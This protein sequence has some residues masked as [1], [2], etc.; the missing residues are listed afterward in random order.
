MAMSPKLLMK[1]LGEAPNLVWMERIDVGEEWGK[2]FH[3]PFANELIHVLEGSARIEYQRSAVTVKVGDTFVV[4]WYL[5]HRDIRL[6]GSAYRADYMFFHWP[7]AEPLLRQIKPAVICTPPGKVKTHLR[8]LM[9]EMLRENANDSPAV[10]A[11]I[12]MVLVEALL[13]LIRHGTHA[14]EPTPGA[15][16]ELA[17]RRHRELA[18]RVEQYLISH[19]HESIRLEKLAHE[20]GVSPFHLCRTVSRELGR[21]VNEILCSARVDKSKR[22]LAGDELSVKEIAAQMG[23]MTPN[24]FGRVFRRLEGVTPTEYRLAI[25]KKIKKAG[26]TVDSPDKKR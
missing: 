17:A 15:V 26:G 22:M 3:L 8:W 19:C 11:R 23:F 24:Y 12:H 25:K 7:A 16:G 21:S 1:A 14:K 5:S 10:M 4:P 13:C 9:H 20:H 6:P 2:Q 18:F